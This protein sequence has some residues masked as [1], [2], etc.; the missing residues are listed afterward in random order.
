MSEGGSC[1]VD[2]ETF[3]GRETIPL[4]LNLNVIIALNLLLSFPLKLVIVYLM[5]SFIDLYLLFF[6]SQHAD[7]MSF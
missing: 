5:D 4:V 1:K 3:S 6:F 7:T 2:S